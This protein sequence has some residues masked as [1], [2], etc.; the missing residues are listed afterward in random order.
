MSGDWCLD[1]E[2]NQEKEVE[3]WN[4]DEENQTPNNWHDLEALHITLT[5]EEDGIL[6]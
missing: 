5:S 1:L 4:E 6:T 2:M 3:G